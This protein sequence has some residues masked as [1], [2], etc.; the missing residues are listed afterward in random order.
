MGYPYLLID[1]AVRIA[2]D[3]RTVT[4]VIVPNDVQEMDA[5]ETPAH[6]HGTVHSSIGY[7]RPRVIP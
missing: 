6:A 3:E 5:V 1:R 7:S 4:C 2:V